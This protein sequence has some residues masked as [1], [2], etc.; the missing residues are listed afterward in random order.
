MTTEIAIIEIPEDKALAVFTAPQGLDPYLDQIAAQARSFVP[1]LSTKKGRD[2]IASIAYR[3]RQSKTAMDKAGKALVDKLK[4]QP[5]LVDAERKRMRE[6]MDSLADEVRKP[7]DEFEAAEAA[8]VQ[9]LKEK[10]EF[11]VNARDIPDQWSSSNI[12]ALIEDIGELVIDQSFEEFEAEAHREKAATIEALNSALVSQKAREAEQAELAR[13]R[14]EAIAREQKEREERIAR[15]AAE[16]A[17][18]E[19]AEAA[20]R[21]KAEAEAKAKAEREAAERREVELK[22]SAERAQREKLEAEE[23]TRQAE[24]K[25]KADAE[26]AAAETE[27]RIK[28]EAAEQAAAVAEEARKRESD[29]MHRKKINNEILAALEPS[30]ITQDQAK[31]IISMIA[32]GQVPHVKITY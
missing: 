31:G 18:R 13:L 3:V 4:E 29:R 24:I 12:A 15:E 6:F 32:K 7:L 25:A 28:R 14:A 16:R 10:V 9:A 2:S 23:R 8:R 21:E 19:A 1:D 30:G 5:K 11:I 26:R 27:A 17:Q 20:A 22:E